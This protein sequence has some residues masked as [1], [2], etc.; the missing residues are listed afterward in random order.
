MLRRSTRAECPCDPRPGDFLDHVDE[1]P[2][3]RH[4]L[5]GPGRSGVVDLELTDHLVGRDS[6][7][8][9][10]SQDVRGGLVRFHPQVGV[11]V[12]V[13]GRRSCSSPR[14]SSFHSTTSRCRSRLTCRLSCSSPVGGTVRSMRGT[15]QACAVARTEKRPGRQPRVR[16]APRPGVGSG[17]LVR[18]GHG[19]GK[20]DGRGSTGVGDVVGPENAAQVVG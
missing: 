10:E 4:G 3:H 15:W 8:G 12:V 16:G 14:P 13:I 5:A 19:R 2:A 11:L 20:R 18:H 17:R 9:M 1:H 6:G 7:A